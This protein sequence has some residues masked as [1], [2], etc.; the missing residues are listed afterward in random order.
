MIESIIALL[1]A[2]GIALFFVEKRLA[3]YITGGISFTALA[4]FQAY[5]G[6][7]IGLIALVLTVVCVERAIAEYRR[8]K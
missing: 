7:M 6:R 2:V 5:Q 3:A 1:M 4:I 8:K